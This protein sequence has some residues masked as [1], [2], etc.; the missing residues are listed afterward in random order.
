MNPQD[1]EENIKSLL[2]LRLGDAGPLGAFQG[3]MPPMPPMPQGVHTGP[4][5]LGPWDGQVPPSGPPAGPPGMGLPVVRPSPSP[6]I[7]NIEDD[8]PRGPPAP[9]EGPPLPPAL[10]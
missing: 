8:S 7:I 9:P 2:G 5:G 6:N 1:I 3:A 10:R 4:P